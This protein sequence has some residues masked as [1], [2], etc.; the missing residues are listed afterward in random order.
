MGLRAALPRLKRP[1]RRAAHLADAL[2][3]HPQPQLALKPAAHQP[4]SEP[5][6][7]RQLAAGHELRHVE[8]AHAPRRPLALALD[9]PRPALDARLAGG[10]L[11]RA[12]PLRAAAAL[13]AR[14]DDG[15]P[16][17]V[18]ERLVDHRAEDDVRVGMR[19]LRD[20]L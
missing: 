20:G 13:V 18:L 16:D 4:R 17:L 15:D 3:L 14:R 12:V 7:A 5:A 11:E 6:E 10:L 1:R 9:R 19:G 2:Q 8:L